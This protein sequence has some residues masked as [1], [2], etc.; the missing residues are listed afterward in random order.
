MPILTSGSTKTVTLGAYDS[1]T[2]QNRSGQAASISVGGTVVNGNHSGSRTYGP[3]PSG[4][5]V[6]L[7]AISGDLYYEVADGA[8]DTKRV[9]A[10]GSSLLAEDGSTVSAGGVS[11][12]AL[13]RATAGDSTA[14]RIGTN[15]AANYSAGGFVVSGGIVTMNVSTAFPSGHPLLPGNYGQ[16]IAPA[17]GWVAGANPGVPST[18]G[19]YR[20]NTNLHNRMVKILSA[21][22]TTLTF[23]LLN[24]DGS[25]A[26]PDGDYSTVGASSTDGWSV[27]TLYRNKDGQPDYF[28]DVLSNNPSI[29]VATYA[30]GGSRAEEAVAALPNML[31]GPKFDLLDLD[32]GTNNIN[33]GTNLAESMQAATLSMSCISQIVDAVIAY[34]ATP[35]VTIP[36]GDST[37]FPTYASYKAQAFAHLRQLILAKAAAT[38]Q[39]VVIDA[40][41]Q[42]VGPDGNM[43]TTASAT[44]DGV[45]IHPHQCFKIAKAELSKMTARFGARPDIGP[46]SIFEDAVTYSQP[47]AQYPNILPNPLFTGSTD[48]TATNITGTKPTGWLINTL[49]EATVA[50]TAGIDKGNGQ[51]YGWQLQVTY[52]ASG[53]AGIQTPSFA[54]ALRR[55]KWYRAGLVFKFNTD[56]VGFA[57]LQGN[58]F[59]NGDANFRGSLVFDTLG[60]GAGLG[61]AGL[62]AKAGDVLTYV[63]NPFFVADAGANP[64]SLSLLYVFYSLSAG[65]ID[66]TVQKAFMQVVDNP[67]SDWAGA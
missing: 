6:S 13:R 7:N 53:R 61:Q 23:A 59:T 41:A 39:M 20:R 50:S 35:R 36:A 43:L 28:L 45:H 34:G 31:A 51:G 66:V 12:R 33:L 65:S 49:T 37:N 8:G 29:L 63:S 5:S 27:M 30:V 1:I 16:L 62:P 11:I 24:P 67:Y 44:N 58:V 22:A 17:V 4:G 25:P 18:L 15:V 38:P 52:S 54:A 56:P 42:S 46:V 10:R 14:A 48:A 32:T 2:L 57:N 21:T 64:A 40:Y 60:V 55:G 47:D 19:T 26:L 3:Y 9:F